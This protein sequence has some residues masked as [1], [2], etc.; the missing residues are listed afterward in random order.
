MTSVAVVVGV[1]AVQ[2]RIELLPVVYAAV[3]AFFIA[4]ASFAINDLCDMELD[5]SSG[6]PNPLTQGRLSSE[7][8]AT[9]AI[10]LAATGVFLSY[11]VNSVLTLVLAVTSAALA[12]GYS[13]F[14]KPKLP[15]MAHLAT[16]YSTGITFVYGW[17]ILEPPSMTMF[18]RV[19]FMFA[20]AGAANFSRELIKV[21]ADYRGDSKWGIRT[22]AVTK[23]PKFA[24]RM[25]LG[26]MTIAVGISFVPAL[27]VM[28]RSSYLVIVSL[29]DILLL[30]L[31]VEVYYRPTTD[32]AHRAK[33][34]IM[35]VM[36]LG[37]FGFLVGPRFEYNSIY[38]VPFEIV[39]GVAFVVL[40][41]RFSA[42]YV[43]PLL[44]RRKRY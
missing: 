15:T 39:T 40:L 20:I 34:N 6:R 37:L 27:L 44:S 24:S 14:L 17:S 9:L 35:G 1:L 31:A 33:G 32:I 36:G 10:S 12:F 30:L 22:L 16:S 18:V 11:L 23:G 28:F 4:A 29:V 43:R 3:S 19:F 8:A 13:I 38:A 2:D 42:M 21:I 25:A 5:A 41:I 26:A 7:T